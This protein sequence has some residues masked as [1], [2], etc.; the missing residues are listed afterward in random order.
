MTKGKFPASRGAV[1]VISAIAASVRSFADATDLQIT[2]TAF[3]IVI[4]L[5]PDLQT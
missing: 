2:I 1:I 4:I 5:D 3:V